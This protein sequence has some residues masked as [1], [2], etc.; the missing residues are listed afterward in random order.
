MIDDIQIDILELT[1]EICQGNFEV[2]LDVCCN[3][4][5]GSIAA[6]LDVNEF[7]EGTQSARLTVNVEDGSPIF[8]S[9]SSTCPGPLL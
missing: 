6:D 1:P 8:S 2:G 4:N 7:A 5:N 9:C 3:Q